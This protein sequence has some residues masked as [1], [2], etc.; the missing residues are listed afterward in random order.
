[1]KKT[2]TA[3]FAIVLGIVML[4][5]C[6]NA[7]NFD[8]DSSNEI[9]VISREDGSGTRGAFIELFSLL[10]KTRDGERTDHT[11]IEAVVVNK[12]DVMLMSVSNDPYAIGYVSLG[13][14]SPEIKPLQ[15]D[16][17]T[18][19]EQNVKSGSYEIARPFNIVTKGEP[20]GLVKDFIDFIMSKEGQEVIDRSYISVLSDAPSFFGEQP[21][22][23]IV[24]AGSSSVTPV[25]EKLKE[26]YVL[27]NPNA[28]IEIQMSDSTSGTMGT[29]EGTCDIGMA[30][31]DLKE[32]ELSQLNC[33]EIA[34]DG[35]ALIVNPSNPTT[36]VTR[37]QVRQI[38][39]GEI[40]MWDEIS[41]DQ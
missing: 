24:V 30:S 12:T 3:L 26:A 22:G 37:E 18:P 38:F 1:M 32:N 13:S 29:I 6:M 31:R 33:T 23:K 35:I 34:L 39:S 36:S 7:S 16:G 21:E 4:A 5:G 10:E 11:S 28:I 27:V 40:L 8:F 20:T 9:D 19:S 15:I 2:M 25:M 14:L 17:A 41:I